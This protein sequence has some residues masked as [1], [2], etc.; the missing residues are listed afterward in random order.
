MRIRSGRGYTGNDGHPPSV[1]MGGLVVSMEPVGDG[2]GVGNSVVVGE[3]MVV[4]N[5]LLGFIFEGEDVGN[6]VGNG[7]GEGVG[8]GVGNGVGRDTGIS[9]SSPRNPSWQLQSWSG[10]PCSFCIQTPPFWHS[11][12]QA[13]SPGGAINSHEKPMKTS[14]HRHPKV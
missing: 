3:G 11:R 2:T 8:K 10:E 14:G 6:G 13:S 7:V 1:L 12:V 5:A 9:Q 4:G